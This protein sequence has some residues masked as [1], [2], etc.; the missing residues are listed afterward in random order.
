MFRMSCVKRSRTSSSTV[1]IAPHLATSCGISWI[2]Q[3]IS[4]KTS[5]TRDVS[6]PTPSPGSLSTPSK[7]YRQGVFLLAT[8]GLCLTHHAKLLLFGG[9][10]VRWA[11]HHPCQLQR[12]CF[13]ATCANPCTP[14]IV[15]SVPH[16]AA[17]L[18][19]IRLSEGCCPSLCSVQVSMQPVPIQHVCRTLPTVL[20]S[21][22]NIS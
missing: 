20:P 3:W 12:Y 4:S 5:S 8:A 7:S 11:V 16:A 13:S 10:R 21:D 19:D 22:D 2:G 15:H 6:M 14:S 18:K 1:W 17:L 9:W